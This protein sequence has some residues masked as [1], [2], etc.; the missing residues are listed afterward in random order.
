MLSWQ[1]MKPWE[2]IW[3]ITGLTQRTMDVSW[4]PRNV[5][6]YGQLLSP[7]WGGGVCVLTKCRWWRG[8]Q[9]KRQ[10]WPEI[11]MPFTGD[12]NWQ[13]DYFFVVIVRGYLPR[14]NKMILCGCSGM[15]SDILIIP[16]PSP[17]FIENTPSIF[18]TTLLYPELGTALGAHKHW[19]LNSNNA[20][21]INQLINEHWTN[22]LDHHVCF[23]EM[24]WQ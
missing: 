13:S 19:C 7:E 20:A 4:G 22:D 18:G 14:N 15:I 12:F 1:R 17:H 10:K 5:I 2:R 24:R 16:P 8:V 3:T 9:Q 23:F 11:W 6:W 21:S